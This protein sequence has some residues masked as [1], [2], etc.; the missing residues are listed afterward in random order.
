SSW[1]I[2][3]YVGCNADGNG[4][5]IR[6]EDENNSDVYADAAFTVQGQLLAT[7]IS[8]TWAINT[9]YNI[10]WNVVHGN[11]AN[12][13]II[14]SRDGNWGGEEEFTI[15]GT[16]D[17][18]NV[19]GFDVANFGTL[20]YAGQGSYS[21]NIAELTPSIIS[22][23][24]KIK[25][26][27]ADT[28]YSVES[29]AAATFNIIGKFQ[30]TAPKLGDIVK[31]DEMFEIKWN[32]W[33][34]ISLVKI[35]YSTDSVNGVEGTWPEIT[36]ST[37]NDGS[38]EWTPT[39]AVAITD[40]LFIKV[41]DITQAGGISDVSD[42][43][44]DV[45]GW[46]EFT[47]AVDTPLEDAV[48]QVGVQHEITWTKHGNISNV[49]VEYSPTLNEVDYVEIAGDIS[50]TGSHLWTPN[51]VTRTLSSAGYIRVSDAA[52]GES[53]NNAVSAN[54]RLVGVINLISP[55][56][57]EI[58]D[59]NTTPNIT[60]KTTGNV[61]KVRIDY[62]KDGGTFTSITAETPGGSGAETSYQW[63]IGDN[64][65]PNVV[66]RVADKNEVT[67]CNATSSLVDPIRIKVIFDITSGTMLPL[68][69]QPVGLES[70]QTIKWGTTGSCPQV[71]LELSVDEDHLVWE[72]I[73]T[74]VTGLVVNTADGIIWDP[75]D[76]RISNF[77][78][79]RVSDSRDLENYADSG[80]FYIRGQ[81]TLDQPNG[82]EDLN[83]G[84]SY[85]IKWTTL[86]TIESVK[87]EYSVDEG[88]TY[89]PTLT[90]NP[91]SLSVTALTDPPLIANGQSTFS[92]SVPDEIS[93][94][95]RV[96]VTDN[97]AGT[98]TDESDANFNIRDVLSITEASFTQGETLLVG[99]TRAIGMTK[100]GSLSA[101]ALEYSSDGVSYDY[102][103]DESNVEATSVDISGA[104][105]YS[106]TWKIPDHIDDNVTV[107]VS[108]ANEANQP[109][110]PAESVDF[111]IKGILN[112]SAPIQDEILGVDDLYDITFTKTGSIDEVEIKYSVNG[113]GY[114][115][116]CE[117]ASNAEATAVD[118]SGVGPS[119]T[120]TWKVPNQISGNITVRV[121]D[122]SDSD[123][124]AESDPFKIAARLKITTPNGGSFY[125]VGHSCP[126]NW[127]QHGNMPDGKVDLVYDTNEGL[128]FY[129]I[130]IATAIDSD[131]LLFDW[132]T[133]D[134]IGDKLRIKIRDNDG[135]TNTIEDI[136]DTNFEIRGKLE[137]LTPPLAG[138]DGEVLLITATKNV[139][140]RKWGNITSVKLEYTIDN[141]NYHSLN[142]DGTVEGAEVVVAT[143]GTGPYP[144]T[145]SYDWVIP[146]N[147]STTVKV[148]VSNYVNSDVYSDSGE[149][150]FLIIRPG[151]GWLTPD[152]EA[153][154]NALTATDPYV[155]TWDTFGTVDN[156]K[157]LYSD[158]SGAT[159]K[160]MFN[161][162]AAVDPATEGTVISNQGV[163]KGTKTLLNIPDDINSSV[164]LMILDAINIAAEKTLKNCQIR[165]ELTLQKPDSSSIWLA[166][167]T[168]RI[169][170]KTKGTLA[171]IK[172]EYS[173]DGGES[174]TDPDGGMI[175][176]MQLAA[177]PEGGNT[178][179]LDWLVDGDAISPICAVRIT[180]NL[181]DQVT[182]Q[183]GNFPIKA[184]FTVVSPTNT[185]T[186]IIDSTKTISWNTIGAVDKVDLY[187]FRESTG[188]W[189]KINNDEEITNNSVGLTTYPWQVADSVSDIAK[190][191]V[192]D[193]SDDTALR[194]S[195]E[196]KIR[197]SLTLI[198]PNDAGEE[199][200]VGRTCSIQ[201]EPHGSIGNVFV[202]YFLDPVWVPV[203][204]P[205]DGD[206]IIANSGSVAWIVPDVLINGS[207]IENALIKV[208]SI[209]W[210]D[211]DPGLSENAFRIIAGFTL[212]KPN[213]GEPV[214]AGTPYTIEWTCTSE[215]ISDV[216]I[217]YSLDG[218]NDDYLYNILATTANDASEIW[219][220]PNDILITDKARIRISDAGDAAAH[221]ESNNN[222]FLRAKLELKQ[223]DGEE[224]FVIGVPNAVKWTCLGDIPQV[225]LEYTTTGDW[226]DKRF[227]ATVTNNGEFSWTI[228][229]DF[230]FSDECLL[231]VSDP[232]DYLAQSDSEAAFRI[233]PGFVMTYPVGTEDFKMNTNETITWTCTA[234]SQLSTVTI[235]YS[236]NGGGS[237]GVL[238]QTDND[239]EELWE[240][241]GNG[242]GDIGVD[243]VTTKAQL[244][245]GDPIDDTISA[246]SEDFDI[247]ANFEI[248]SPNG[249]GTY[250]V[251]DDVPISWTCNGT[252]S[253]VDLYYSTGGVWNPIET[254]VANSDTLN[255]GASVDGSY[256][257][258]ANDAISKTVR[259]RVADSVSDH[260]YADDD[261]D[262]DFRIKGNIWM[263]APVLNDSWDI[264]Q[265]YD[266][267]WGWI[268]TIPEVKITYSINGLAG[269][270]NP[271][272]E[273][274]GTADDGII[275][276]AVGSGGAASEA[277][278]SWT[279]PDEAAADTV[280]RIVD[281]RGSE[282]DVTDDTGSFHIVGYIIAKEPVSTDV[283]EVDKTFDIKWEWGGT[284][285]EVKIT[286]STNG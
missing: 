162:G 135:A 67:Y 65:S 153:S 129:L 239:G 130:P 255:I 152:P 196:F 283:L 240:S 70:P 249:G 262:A 124:Y 29:L 16:T 75:V 63:N 173:K 233:V 79:I 204:D 177:N 166:G 44:V 122:T 193:V 191:K 213:G 248:I 102:C 27:D 34:T 185:D 211:T 253:E 28:D 10:T 69:G 195:S 223:P 78:I 56:G 159:W 139:S 45:K 182:D 7:N 167:G 281:S 245:V 32:K 254:D 14:G 220:V 81:I 154:L 229:D 174:F 200:I 104:A 89:P 241:I 21:W 224:T 263:K 1:D 3:E 155:F 17:A 257:W 244:R 123:V 158:T 101:V 86:G 49:N 60:W 106:F 234:P 39:D 20:G 22:D 144:E 126:I 118:I 221:D 278:F 2:P 24:V 169:E 157:I 261:S 62:S 132:T 275:A 6:V 243:K 26:L 35:E 140:W 133:P 64:P 33:G 88:G 260:P 97:N 73:I 267:K 47:D 59:V 18:D 251:G 8:D 131:A 94:K 164:Y 258:S 178:F 117:D 54:F 202:E 85:D 105:P 163:N 11:I 181:N 121:M 214:F 265:D 111:K 198:Y 134:A 149:V 279:I 274:Y 19:T 199:A 156:V 170:W 188:Q 72:P 160:D 52:D 55:T 125:E 119:Y 276:N 219:D 238:M 205:L 273:T 57:G 230:N 226:A 110:L 74:P 116:Y 146:D 222:F 58:Y 203:P 38:F 179:Y 66:V 90:D 237:W 266:V 145:Y 51:A 5:V 231:R 115:E 209:D 242:A 76:D 227:I 284:M 247:S 183:F 48:W 53:A 98:V 168:G 37:D 171:T 212:L 113:A 31:I 271:V 216:T 84:S 235:W 218:G 41:T 148:K 207:S 120:F 208:R 96:K 103:K 114:N 99:T 197:G 61:D 109:A 4:Y 256:N 269:P 36:A 206:N 128:S 180:D 236:V 270:F 172:I 127:K 87:L 136:S 186:W 138:E 190:I 80:E 201:W 252:V 46:F 232:N 184:S 43:A 280:I 250:T 259:V 13:N 175:A 83:V 42:D 143:P 137:L 282:T 187:Y 100:V 189:V 92:W 210:P 23:Q 141:V 142:W 108:S 192:V 277:A 30:V 286:Y 93:A 161:D 272:L 150:P 107:R 215:Y 268:G 151:F 228:L 95:V 12:V 285:P 77:C 68:A 264:G 165:G 246:K 40:N 9:S 112:V 15:I 176:P 50:N 91:I 194:E 82:G 71:K 217:D 147:P 25:V 225:N